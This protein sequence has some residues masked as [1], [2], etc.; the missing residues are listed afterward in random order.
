MEFLK[1]KMSRIGY[2]LCHFKTIIKPVSMN[3]IL[4][5]PGEV[6]V[7]FKRGRHKDKSKTH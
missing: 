5:T 2:Q 3:L 7:Q 1:R 4:D 6:W